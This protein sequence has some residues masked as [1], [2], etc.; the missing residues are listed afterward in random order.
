MADS[1][2]A[3]ILLTTAVLV[4][5]MARRLNLLSVLGYLF[6][7][8]LLGPH[9]LNPAVDDEAIYLLGEY[10]AVFLAFT[11]R[12]EFSLP[13]MVAMKW[14]VLGRGGSQVLLGMLAFA[15]V[16]WL[17]G[18]D[19]TISLVLGCALALSSTAFAI[20]QLVALGSP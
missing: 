5:G 9:V 17:T 4:V 10:G 20:R 3:Q 15:A 2:L 19:I 13:R 16:A 12:L 6:V 1:A 18:I 7:G 11:P 14:E 8:M